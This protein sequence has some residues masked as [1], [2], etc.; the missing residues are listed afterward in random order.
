MHI[1][2]RVALAVALALLLLLGFLRVARELL[3]RTI[4]EVPSLDNEVSFPRRRRTRLTAASR[5]SLS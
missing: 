4:Y 2:A 1:V 3:S 5:G